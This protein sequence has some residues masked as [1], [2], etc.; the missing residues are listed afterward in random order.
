MD[1]NK[2][3]EVIDMS[4]EKEQPKKKK[5]KIFGDPVVELEESI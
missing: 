4:E 1:I 3:N 5:G 2:I